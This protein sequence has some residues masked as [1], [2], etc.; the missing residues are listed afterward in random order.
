MVAR[1]SEPNAQIAWFA[2][3][4]PR[5]IADWLYRA[6]VMK[7]TTPLV[8]DLSRASLFA[9]VVGRATGLQDGIL[10][11]KFKKAIEFATLDFIVKSYEDEDRKAT[12]YL[13]FLISMAGRLQVASLL[14]IFVKWLITKRFEAPPGEDN[15][16]HVSL[17]RTVLGFGIKDAGV[18]ALC[19]KDIHD[20]RY[21]AYCYRALWYRN[22]DNALKYLPVIARH[23]LKFGSV[24]VDFLHFWSAVSMQFDR[25]DLVRRLKT[26]LKKIRDR[27]LKCHIRDV[28]A[29]FDWSIYFWPGRIDAIPPGEMSEEDIA[30]VIRM[31]QGVPISKIT[32]EQEKEYI[33]MELETVTIPL[34]LEKMS[35][36]SA[37]LEGLA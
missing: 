9:Y 33:E 18:Y 16:L 3:K 4:R 8:F 7:D 29:R 1:I 26:V 19:R 35:H 22:P 36:T 25:Q 17:L 34:W 23:H 11:P 15:S 14:G 12:R 5:E 32:S 27:K 20:P 10:I 2:E 31:G 37:T 28:L 6:V 30:A 13:E 24:V 21:A